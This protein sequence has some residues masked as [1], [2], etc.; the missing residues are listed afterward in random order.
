MQ[1]GLNYYPIRSF[2][3]SIQCHYFFSQLPFQ[4]PNFQKWVYVAIWLVVGLPTVEIL[5]LNHKS[6]ENWFVIIIFDQI[7]LSFRLDEQNLPNKFLVVY[8]LDW[9]HGKN[10]F[11]F[12]NSNFQYLWKAK[13]FYQKKTDPPPPKKKKKQKMPSFVF[14]FCFGEPRHKCL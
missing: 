5:I 6:I 7:L 2:Q 9:K 14:F 8:N 10:N 12:Q 13:L 4:S 1:L 3:S 11:K